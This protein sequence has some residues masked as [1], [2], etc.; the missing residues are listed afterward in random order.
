[1]RKIKVFQRLV[2]GHLIVLNCSFYFIKKSE[3]LFVSLTFVLLI[4]Y[5]TFLFFKS[6]KQK[7]KTVN[8]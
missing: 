5:A 2:L 4:M 3:Y 8:S 6:V 1:M 7:N